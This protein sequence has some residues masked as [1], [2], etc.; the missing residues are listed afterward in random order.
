[1]TTTAQPSALPPGLRVEAYDEPNPW[2]SLDLPAAADHFSFVLVSDRTGNARPGVFE[3][4]LAVTDLLAPSFAIQLGDLIEGYTDDDAE[5]ARQWSHIEGMFAGMRTPMFLTPG[6]HDVSTPKMEQRWRERYGRCHY[7]FRYG[8]ALFIILNTQENPA[9]LTPNVAEHLHALEE[10]LVQYPIA[11]RE[12]VAELFDWNGTQPASVGEE[13]L[14][15]VEHALR[16]NTDARWTFLC[17]HMPLWQGSHPAWNR[18]RAA[19][20]DRPYHAFAGHVHNY[21]HERAGANSHVRLGPTGGLWVLGGPEGNLDHVTQVTVT[22]NG[23]AVA[24]ILLD[25][26]RDVDGQPLLPVATRSV[27]TRM[28]ARG[29]GRRPDSGTG[30]RAGGCHARRT[31]PSRLRPHRRAR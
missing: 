15:D 9:E 6:N 31:D 4:G 11:A 5:L 16:E 21:R 1:M 14:A 18:I 25:G 3:R 10:R 19:L 12:Q 2:T 13:Q 20:R 30:V 26:I 8:D 22:K 24:N 7:H 17:M 27:P 23:P 29:D 28:P